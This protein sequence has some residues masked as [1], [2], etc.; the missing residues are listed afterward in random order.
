M[1]SNC[2]Q[3]IVDSDSDEYYLASLGGAKESVS[4]IPAHTSYS[5]SY[6]SIIVYM[7]RV[8]NFQLKA[9]LSKLCI[10]FRILQ[11]LLTKLGSGFAREHSSLAA[12]GLVVRDR[13]WTAVTAPTRWHIIPRRGSRYISFQEDPKGDSASKKTRSMIVQHLS[14]HPFNNIRYSVSYPK[15]VSYIPVSKPNS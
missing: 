4:F 15:K 8:Q 2:K 5:C 1:I 3:H 11:S 13:G 9:A 10:V 12:G 6:S 7:L 14:K